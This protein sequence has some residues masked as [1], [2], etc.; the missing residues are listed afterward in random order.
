MRTSPTQCWCHATISIIFTHNIIG[1]LTKYSGIQPSHHPD[2]FND[3]PR[4]LKFYPACLPSELDLVVRRTSRNSSHSHKF[5][6][7]S[8][9][10]KER[11]LQSAEVQLIRSRFLSLSIFTG[12][13]VQIM[14]R[15]RC[16]SCTI[17]EG[18][19]GQ[20]G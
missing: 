4:V 18:L 2:L 17:N 11:S 15:N 9:S 1:S 13:A 8:H 16:F 3:R 19:S 5:L 10:E 12:C 14:N 6:L 20:R 7:C